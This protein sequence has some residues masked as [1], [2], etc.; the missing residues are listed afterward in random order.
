MEES[1]D[2]T[3]CKAMEAIDS[4]HWT[5]GDSRK[6]T[7]TAGSDVVQ[8]GRPIFDDFSNI[9]GRISAISRRMLSS[10]WSSVCGLSA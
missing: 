1:W 8:S 4:D 9:C 6:R 3:R 5:T 7:A 2:R 10:K